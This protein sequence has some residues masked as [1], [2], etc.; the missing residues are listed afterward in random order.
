M[1]YIPGTVNIQQ[2]HVFY[3]NIAECNLNASQGTKQN[4]MSIAQTILHLFW[5]LNKV[6][7][8]RQGR[9]GIKTHILFMANTT[10]R[11][12]GISLSLS[13]QLW[14]DLEV[15]IQKMAWTTHSLFFRNSANTR[16]P[17]QMNT[18]K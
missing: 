6:L 2:Q 9:A 12:S 7:P 18:G 11:N 13:G 4:Y 5:E 8:R 10:E 15:I 1:P 16:S 17:S 14:D 3:R